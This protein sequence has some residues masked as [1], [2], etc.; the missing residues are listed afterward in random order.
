MKTLAVALALLASLPAFSAPP[1][2][3]DFPVNIIVRCNRL[4]PHRG[5]EYQQIGVTIDGKPYE[6]I[7]EAEAGMLAPGT[8]KAR[9]YH[10]SYWYKQEAHNIDMMYELL[11]PNHKTWTVQLSGIGYDPCGTTD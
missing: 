9:I 3:A 7:G 1:N 8:Y 11:L 5:S 4:R 2:P 10:R 6:F